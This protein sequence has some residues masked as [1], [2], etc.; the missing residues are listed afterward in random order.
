MT[1]KQKTKIQHLSKFQLLD[2]KLSKINMFGGYKKKEQNSDKFIHFWFCE[3]PIE[4]V[5]NWQ[6]SKNN[7]RIKYDP[8]HLY[9]NNVEKV[10]ISVI[11]I[12]ENDRLNIIKIYK[13][14]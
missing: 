6:L 14:R 7:C 5:K 8:Y 1:K 12:Y 2:K 9:L 3:I 10:I 11:T 4:N 13:A